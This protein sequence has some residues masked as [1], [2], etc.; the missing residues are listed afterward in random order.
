MEQSASKVACHLTPLDEQPWGIEISLFNVWKQQLALTEVIISGKIM[1][2]LHLKY[3]WLH[4]LYLNY[5]QICC[6]R[7]T[8]Q[9]MGRPWRNYVWKLNW[10]SLI[11]KHEV[12]LWCNHCLGQSSMFAVTIICRGYLLVGDDKASCCFVEHTVALKHM[13]F[14]QCSGI[15][16]WQ[17]IRNI[18]MKPLLFRQNYHK[19][20]EL[21]PAA[22]HLGKDIFWNSLLCITVSVKS[23]VIYSLL[24]KTIML[25]FVMPYTRRNMCLSLEK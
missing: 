4:L 12:F 14:C 13:V 20:G 22:E 18:V 2:F 15:S 17:I 24:R 9:Y 23:E 25:P 21:T 16:A 7:V 3:I 10:R 11:M 8:S 1:I 19:S 5:A 6:N